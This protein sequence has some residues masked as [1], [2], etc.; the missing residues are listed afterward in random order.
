VSHALA[1]DTDKG[2]KVFGI[3]GLGGQKVVSPPLATELS[4]EFGLADSAS[5]VHNDQ[6]G[7]LFGPQILESLEFLLSVQKLRF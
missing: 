5:P 1:K 7:P 2:P 4:Q 6:L 3:F